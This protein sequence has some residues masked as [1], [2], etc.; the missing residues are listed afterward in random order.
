MKKWLWTV[1]ALVA[2]LVIGWAGQAR[3]GD[4]ATAMNCDPSQ[5]PPGCCTIAECEALCGGNVNWTAC[6]WQSL[7]YDANGKLM[8]SV[9]EEQAKRIANEYLKQ[10]GSEG[11]ME[12]VS[13][14]PQSFLVVVHWET[15]DRQ[16]LEIDRQ[17]GWI[18][19]LNT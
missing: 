4:V 14:S 16:K 5:C 11:C 19:E 2:L 17:T 10:R 3:T 6:S 18:R 15:A 8:E 7:S 9:T 12:L 1:P 13:S